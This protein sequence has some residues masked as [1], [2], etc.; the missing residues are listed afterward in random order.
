MN[1][2]EITKIGNLYIASALSP[3]RG[4]KW[5]TREGMSRG[6]LVHELIVLGFHQQDI[7]DAFYA[8]DPH[9]LELDS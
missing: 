6:A 1:A 8:A 5:G 9:W 7:G 3:D 2:I 4:V